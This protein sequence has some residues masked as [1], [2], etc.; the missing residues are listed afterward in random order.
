MSEKVCIDKRIALLALFTLPIFGL[1]LLSSTINS[2]KIGRQS[3]ASEEKALIS[4]PT[5]TI[6]PGSRAVCMIA[7]KN[8]LNMTVDLYV[9][10]N[11]DLLPQPMKIYYSDGTKVQY[12][13]LAGYPFP[14]NMEKPFY[15]IKMD[16]L[17]GNGWV[18]FVGTQNVQES[19]IDDF[20]KDC[21]VAIRVNP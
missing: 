17:P 13:S 18:K 10:Q 1:F 20:V 16:L 4:V 3:K 8:T 11:E 2:Q 21:S 15:T 6:P 14:D 12:M 7:K 9:R 19:L 5:K